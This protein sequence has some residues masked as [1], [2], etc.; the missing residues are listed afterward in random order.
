MAAG[1]VGYG[2]YI[3]KYRINRKIIGKAWSTGGRG[4]NSVRY[5]DEDIITMAAEACMNAVSHAGMD[6]SA[7]LDAIYLGT[8]SY[9]HIE[10]SSLGIIGEVLRAKEEM[11]VADF[12]ASP[13]AAVAALK[14]CRD[15]LESGR[16]GYGL[17][18]GSEARAVSP[19]SPEE[20]NCGDGAAAVLLGR[21]NTIADIQEVY[22]CAGNILDR[23]REAEAPY[24]KEYEPRFTRNYGYLNNIIKAKD[25]ILSR[26]HARVEDFQ[27]VVL[28][29]PD[30][31]MVKK[32]A[33]TLGIR[34]EQLEAGDH[35]N[36]LGDLGAA[37]V[38]V[39]LASVLDKAEPGDRIL[40]LSYGSGVSDAVA[41]R[42]NE[43]IGTR[44][45]KTGSLESYVRSRV[46]LEEYTAF[47]RLKGALKKETVPTRLGLPPASSALWRD[48]RDIREMNGIRC[49][50]C[51]YVNYPPSIRKICIRCGD[52][53]F[54][55]VV[56]S[57]RG[58]VHTY[59]I[60]LYVPSPLQSPQPI[61]IADLDDGNRYRALGTEIR[62]HED[63][64]V[65]MPVELVLRKIITEDGLGVY[66]NVFRPLR[67]A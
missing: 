37:S 43:A 2:V 42:V 29:Q 5:H 15:A 58:T 9:P 16:I 20:M 49:K 27:H 36:A 57:R 8:D 63:I 40:L 3:P 26:M 47:A 38:L 34:P 60:S 10:S 67:T 21:E 44:R 48:G 25:G 66:G 62:S 30:A 17:V 7:Q 45:N 51:G 52:R 24:L 35:V 32:A 65:E 14:A 13:R 12:T 28:Q 46:D 1:I 61:I 56:L 31:R 6:A 23:W 11:D 54:D 33:R 4:E 41:L 55:K 22:T 64:R 59:C 50:K 53:E 19:G 18:T 39:G